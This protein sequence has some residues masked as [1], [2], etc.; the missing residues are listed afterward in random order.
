[1]G[2]RERTF[3]ILVVDDEDDVRSLLGLML[4]KR[5]YLVE[6]AGDGKEAL[7]KVAASKPDLILLDIHMPGMDGFQV[8]RHLRSDPGNEKI[9]VIFCTA[10]RIPDIIKSIKSPGDDYMH[11][12]FDSRLLH[13]KINKILG[14]ESPD[15]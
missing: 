9:P 11:K 6:E 10:L 1:M 4:A 12:P 15:T 2:V 7:E 3:K 8:Y 5:N 13:E 14:R